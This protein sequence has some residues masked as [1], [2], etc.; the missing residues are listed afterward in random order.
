MNSNGGSVQRY[1][2]SERSWGKCTYS[3]NTS[4]QLHQDRNLRCKWFVQSRGWSFL[5][6]HILRHHSQHRQSL[7]CEENQFQCTWIE[8]VIENWISILIGPCPF[9]GWELRNKNWKGNWKMNLVLSLVPPP[10]VTEQEV[11]LPHGP[12]SQST[13]QS[14][15]YFFL[16]FCHTSTVNWTK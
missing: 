3:F 12:T 10:Q 13:K 6:K 7:A 5:Q 9:F 16:V 1:Q 8:R 11:Q 4:H 2:Y 14:K 15:I